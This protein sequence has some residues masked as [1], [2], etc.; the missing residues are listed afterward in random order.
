MERQFEGVHILEG[1]E[2]L[3]G[4]IVRIG[5]RISRTCILALASIGM[6]GGCGEGGERRCA[7]GEEES[8]GCLCAEP[9]SWWNDIEVPSDP[10]EGIRPFPEIIHVCE[11]R[12]DDAFFLDF[13]IEWVVEN[14][15]PEYVYFIEYL[16]DR[17]VLIGTILF[18]GGW[19]IRSDG[20]GISMSREI[21]DRVV[22][23]EGRIEGL[24]FSGTSGKLMNEYS[25][26]PR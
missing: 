4:V 12:M 26:V 11:M 5:D 16:F 20:V 18:V 7:I 25:L 13:P 17:Q 9:L 23:T 2:I 15:Q 24:V 21:Y 22:V 3:S 19:Q 6:I 1:I 10:S 14:S 8:S